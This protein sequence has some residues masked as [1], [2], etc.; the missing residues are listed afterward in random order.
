MKRF[1]LRIFSLCIALLLLCSPLAAFAVTPPLTGRQV[2][3]GC[4]EVDG[5]FEK[6]GL[7]NCTGYVYDY[8]MAIA[9]Y[10]GWEY[11][12]VSMTW[13]D[14]VEQLAAGQI[15]I[16][17]NL[18]QTPARQTRFDYSA[19]P[20][21]YSTCMLCTA[22]DDVRLAYEDFEAFDGITI[23]TI[24]GTV[25]ALNF[26]DF[27]AQHDFS[28]TLY[29]YATDDALLAAARDHRLDAILL[30]STRRCESLRVI[31]SFGTRPVY[32][33]VSR[34]ADGLLEDLNHA[35][36]NL[37]SG[38]RHFDFL[39]DRKHFSQLHAERP[40]FTLAEQRYID[41]QRLHTIALP[42]AQPPIS[43]FDGQADAMAGVLPDFLDLL[44]Q[45]SGLR[46][47]YLPQ[48]EA[49]VLSDGF[50][51]A[52]G[53]CL[54]AVISDFTMFSAAAHTDLTTQGFELPRAFCTLR[55]SDFSPTLSGI[56]AV[57]A[58]SAVGARRQLAQLYPALQ[59]EVLP[60]VADCLKAVA[61]QRVDAAQL[62]LYT[63]QYLMDSLQIDG[64]VLTNAPG[65]TE[66]LRI[67][68]CEDEAEELLPIL[69]KT[70]MSINDYE[71]ESLLVRHTV[72]SLQ[73]SWRGFIT[74]HARSILLGCILVFTT[75]LM[76]LAR[77]VHL[78][79]RRNDALAAL[80]RQMRFDTLTGLYNRQ[81]FFEKSYDML[82]A[83]PDIAFSLL[84]M[85]L[86]RFKLFNDLYGAKAGDALLCRIADRLRHYIT[87]TCTVGYLTADHF[88][89][90]AP[91]DLLDFPAT[92]ERAL[93]S[94]SNMVEGFELIP[95]FGIYHITP[96]DIALGT[97]VDLMCDRA[98]LALRTAKNNYMTHYAVYRPSLIED[99]KSAQAIL[100][101]TTLALEGEQFRPFF[102]PQY[103][104]RT[105]KII[106]AEA[107][108][109]WVH[110]TRGL[111][112]PAEFIPVF[113]QNG[114]IARLDRSIW[115]QVCRQLHG[116]IDAGLSPVPISVNVSRVELYDPDLCDY[117]CHLLTDWQIPSHLLHLEITESAY[118]E[119]AAQLIAM[120]RQLQDCGFWVEM[121]DFGSGYSSLNSLKDVP[122]NALKLDMQFL[123]LDDETGR[124]ECILRSVVQM[125]QRLSLPMIAEGV[126]TERQAALLADAGCTLMQGYL[127]S[128]PVSAQT[129]EE[130]LAAECTGATV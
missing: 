44:S 77:T 30:E 110:P 54:T 85:D 17:P 120:V 65:C 86:D 48:Q 111:I 26:A 55:G 130:M 98:L 73:P 126:E 102:Q 14:A 82:L 56:V 29:Y 93:Q 16:V 23:G 27:R 32:F 84:R 94:F 8:L 59:V 42:A 63:A 106:G 78:Q 81:T 51:A 58:A 80:N 116:W 31:A 36:D 115:R 40:S 76:V 113:E 18:H 74:D 66:Q 12:F 112:S 114:L 109:R 41:A 122:V 28:S 68:V 24:S 125:V 47:Q 92:A 20:M 121:D 129:F 10:T 7:G 5:L 90:C 49:V 119:N 2:R 15:D 9:R 64:L 21:G 96:N 123:S 128:H 70:L 33:G 39:L 75:L 117:L 37:K 3:V 62:N 105:G 108:A 19:L 79:K 46:L 60:T 57:D 95:C 13:E 91:T 104:Y 1:G 124:G 50:A 67:L 72:Y 88:A 52:S 89:I 99:L 4:A 53:S 69:D 100:G 127:F 83:N 97:S 43:Y 71:F 6:D 61:E 118:A 22:D 34:E 107:L 101:D 87:P 35:M 11:T 103:N 38:N 25:M 45:K